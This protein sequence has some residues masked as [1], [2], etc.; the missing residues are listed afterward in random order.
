MITEEQRK[1]R[2]K[3]IG[4]SDAAAVLGLSR[5]KSPLA[6]WGAKTGFIPDEPVE[7][8]ATEVGNELEDLCAKLFE[9][10]TGKKVHRVNE[11]VFHPNYPF[12]AANLD[13]RV[14]GED[15]ILEIKTAG[16]W[17]AKDWL[18]EDMPQEVILQV[19]HQL[20]VTGC[21][22]GYACILVGGNQSFD[23]RR[24]D[25]DPIIIGEMMKK[26]A[27]FWTTYVEP[28]VMPQ[29]VTKNDGDVLYKLFPRG[30]DEANPMQLDDEAVRIIEGLQALK[31]D[32]RTL[33]GAIEKEENVLKLR[34]GDKAAGVAGNFKVTWKNQETTRLDSKALKE[35]Q[36]QVYE[37]FAKT[38][39]SRVFRVSEIKTR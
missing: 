4:S 3:F 12:I 19:M 23:W 25:R 32:L 30:Q 13:R 9:R 16:A 21:S 18:G 20:A 39:G 36:P 31:T 1:E 22:H 7:N 26:E 5:W 10:R 38:T 14:V 24:I 11:T 28:K 17:A 35:K 2:V 15:A 34:L 37:Q 6:V 29:I 8:L 33:E 27:A